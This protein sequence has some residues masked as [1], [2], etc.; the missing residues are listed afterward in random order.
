ME[1]EE[2]AAELH[3]IVETRDVHHYHVKNLINGNQSNYSKV[4]NKNGCNVALGTQR[5]ERPKRNCGSLN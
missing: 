1:K 3:K 2:E 5:I 4:S